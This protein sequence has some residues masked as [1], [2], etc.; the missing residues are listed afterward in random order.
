MVRSSAG[1]DIEAACGQLAV[2]EK[3][4]KAKSKPTITETLS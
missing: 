3:K 1:E 2:E 4:S